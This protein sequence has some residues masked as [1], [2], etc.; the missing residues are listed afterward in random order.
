[1]I[2][3]L[4]L[5]SVAILALSA[6]SNGYDEEERLQRIQKQRNEISEA[7]TKGKQCMAKHPDIE[8]CVE[9]CEAV[10]WSHTEEQAC[11]KGIVM[12]DE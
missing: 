7:E 1:M 4:L 8:G 12:P 11:L 10:Y 9:Y 2:K 5:T 6:C 3:Q